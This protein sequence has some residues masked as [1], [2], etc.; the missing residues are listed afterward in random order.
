MKY[1]VIEESGGQRKVTEGDE[2]LVDLMSDVEGEGKSQTKMSVD[3]GKAF[4]FDKV[5]VVGDD[6]GEANIGRPY[7][8]GASVKAE[9]VEPVVKGEKLFIYKFKAKKGYRRKTGHRQRY[10]KVKILSIVG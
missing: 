10:T 2:I 5:L 3:A 9:V 1:A 7:V 8:S 4:E 6:E